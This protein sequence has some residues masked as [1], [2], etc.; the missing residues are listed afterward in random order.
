VVA[1]PSSYLQLSSAY[2]DD[3][4]RAEQMGWPTARLNGHHLD[5]LTH[6]DI[7]ADLVVDLTASARRALP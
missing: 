7:I 3:R 2:D 6:P 4:R 5:L 1:A